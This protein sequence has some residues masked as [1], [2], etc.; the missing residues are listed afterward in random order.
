MNDTRYTPPEAQVRDIAADARAEDVA[1]PPKVLAQIRGAWL[2]CLVSAAVTLFES[3]A[4]LARHEADAPIGLLDVP[5]ILAMAFG[6]SRK[7]RICAVVMLVYFVT[8]MYLVYRSAG[9]L[10]GW[11]WS[12]VLLV[13]Y[14]QGIAGTLEYHRHRQA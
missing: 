12:I 6:I 8:S 11:W 5:F 4:A 1:V 9:H 7:S 2:A 13:L 14:A 10:G 3:L